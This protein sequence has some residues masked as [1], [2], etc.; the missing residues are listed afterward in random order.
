MKES[1]LVT[2]GAGYIGSH[3]A[4]ALAAAGF[5]PV[6]FDN[7]SGGRR[8]AVRW[9]EL[10][11]GDLADPAALAALFKTHRFRAVLH[12][13]ASIE[14]G[15]SVA[16][17]ARYY[18]NNVVNTLQLLEAMH[19]A[20]VD[21]LVY[22]S[23]CAVYGEPQVLPIPE[24]HPQAPIS[25][26]GWTK[27]M[28]ERIILDQASAHGLRYAILRYFNAA[29]ADPDGETGEMH[30]PESHLIPLLFDAALGKNAGA[31]V[32]GD[33]YPTAD[34]SCVRDYVHVGDLA[35][36]HL[37]ALRRLL[38]GGGSGIWN[39]ANQTGFSVREVIARVQAVT[40]RVFPVR[41]GARRPG[42]LPVLVGDAHAARDALGWVPR[43]SDLDTIIGTGWDW[44]RRMRA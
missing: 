30:E 39:L 8:E 31:A 20:G 34:G 28:A 44:H 15:E 29:G 5:E 14:V 22:S 21:T 10:I 25:P 16:E 33:D 26:Y 36:A 37:L 40:G 42:D 43:F 32:F 6:V 24:S 2:G 35:D 18:R 3:A 27:A 1:I 9:G 17:P 23:S 41:C 7:L 4:K 38:S 19:G 12:F 11:E 13:A